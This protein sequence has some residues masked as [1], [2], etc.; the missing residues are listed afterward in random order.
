MCAMC[1]SVC[2]GIIR[3]K[4]A[5]YVFNCYYMYLISIIYV[6][7]IVEMC[8]HR[9]AHIR[10]WPS[11]Q[12][13]RRRA[14][15]CC[16]RVEKQTVSVELTLYSPGRRCFR[17]W[18]FWFNRSSMDKIISS[19]AH[20]RPFKLPR[21]RMRA[22]LGLV[23]LAVC[24]LVAVAYQAFQQEINIRNLRSQI[25]LTTEQVRVKEDEIV[26]V[27]LKI[28]QINDQLA[29]FK[30]EKD[31]LVKKK[32]EL[33]KTKED[34][35]KGLDTCQKQKADSEKKKIESTAALQKLKVDHSNEEQKFQE[36]VK[37]L[38]KQIFDRDAQL[39][40]FVDENK[41]EGKKLCAENKPPQ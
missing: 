29:P 14:G 3:K 31:E 33:K 32:T 37:T 13:W 1:V 9:F 36:E 12:S 19:S 17:K 10:A 41:Q 24:V 38:Q 18:L 11:S 16:I 6:C 8:F 4:Y 21:S 20:E 28:Q 35:E 2:R 22:V 30:K 7:L 27:K 39:C 15:L 5:G 34:T 23:F 40:K 25:D 26:Q